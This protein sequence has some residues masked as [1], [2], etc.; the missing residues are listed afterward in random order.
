MS[1]YNQP[2]VYPT[3]VWLEVTGKGTCH[4]PISRGEILPVSVSDSI[5]IDL[6]SYI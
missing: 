6:Q 1:L 5:E 4:T 2:G 3:Q